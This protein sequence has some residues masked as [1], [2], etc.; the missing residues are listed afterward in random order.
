MT[1]RRRARRLLAVM[2]HPDDVEIAVGGTLFHLRTLG[3]K[4]GIVTMTAGDCGSPTRRSEEIARIRY[5]ESKAAANVLG[6]WHACVGLMDL[7]VFANAENLRKVVEVLREFNPDVLITHSPVDYMI[8]HEETSRLIRA[9]SFAIAI[10]NY[11]TRQGMAATRSRATPAL[12]Y[13]DPIEGINPLGERVYPQFYVDIKQQLSMKKKMLACHASQRKWLRA[14]HGV[15]EYI[16][17]MVAWAGGYG[18]ECGVTYAEGFRQHLGHAYPRDP[19]LQEALAPYVH[20]RKL[21]GRAVG[22]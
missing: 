5:A 20:E 17:Q 14:H 1:Q 15:D 4:L 7:E 9:A 13:G 11:Q 18:R 19:I 3:W 6:A 22:S 16:K 8:D 2:A 21:S 12:Y 10:P